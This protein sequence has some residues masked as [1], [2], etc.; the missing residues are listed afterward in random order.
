M[1]YLCAIRAAT[2]Y[3]L[4][5]LDLFESATQVAIFHSYVAHAIGLLLWYCAWFYIRPFKGFKREDLFN[6]IYIFLFLLLPSIIIFYGYYNRLIF[7][8]GEEKIDGYWRFTLNEDH[9]IS[10]FTLWHSYVIMSILVVVLFVISIIREQKDRVK[11]V[12]LTIFFIISPIVYT[13]LQTS[14]Q[15]GDW[16]IPNVALNY[17]I[18][19][20]I[21]SWFVSNYRLFENSFEAANT[22]LLNSISDLAI[23]TDLS[24]N[25]SNANQQAMEVMEILPKQN[26]VEVIAANSSLTAKQIRQEIASL[27]N[28]EQT[29]YEVPIIDTNNQERQMEM[30]LS[31]YKKADQIIGYTFLLTDL[32]DIRQKEMELE[33][34]HDTKDRLFAIVSHD[35]R[36]PALAF[37]GISKK[38]NYLIQKEDFDTLHK[39]GANIEKAAFSLNSLLDNLLN[40]ALQQRNVLPYAPMSLKVKEATEEIYDLFYQ[41]AEDKGVEL[42]VDIEEGITV[43]SDPNAFTTIVR[44]LVDNAIKYTPVGGTV[45]VSSTNMNEGVLLKVA[46]TGI[47]MKQTTIDSIFDLQK[48]KSQDGTEGEKGTGLGL[49]LVKD[50]VNLNKGSINVVSKWNGGTTFE[51]FLPAA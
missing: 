12:I 8:F 26:I 51:V 44:N 45:E 20:V 23:S 30:K 5:Q 39:F 38:V 1:F 9:F 22:D 13:F 14:L 21:V 2:E 33:A 18:L 34:L 25:I 3:Y 43:F 16:T 10:Q 41:I 46:D 36:K 19:S 32:S 49:T 24:Y 28:Q 29:K 47:G 48:S 37:R 27:A 11:K 6:R 17:L 40:W 50:L 31:A 4:Q 7:Y 42:V 15:Q 35:L